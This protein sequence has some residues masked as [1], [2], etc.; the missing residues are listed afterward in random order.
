MSE[1]E[2]ASS[3]EENQ[4][5]WP[6]WL[7]RTVGALAAATALVGGV[8]GL[9]GSIGKLDDF[10]DVFCKIIPVC[11]K[12][13]WVAEAPARIARRIT[14]DEEFVFPALTR[15]PPL[16]PVKGSERYEDV[17]DDPKAVT[18]TCAGLGTKAWKLK[19]GEIILDSD[20]LITKGW[21]S[22]SWIGEPRGPDLARF[23]AEAKNKLGWT[24][25]FYAHNSC[26]TGQHCFIPPTDIIANAD[27]TTISAEDCGHMSVGEM[28][29]TEDRSQLSVWIRGTPRNPTVWTI[30]AKQSVYK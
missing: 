26:Q 13:Q 4:K 9:L 16:G 22:S 19:T 3:Q 2:V 12:P 1:T 8:G 23:D 5:S 24:P 29:Y 17:A 28:N 7:R 27:S 10:P 11:A 30:I 14:Q 25:G 6:R 20:P 15:T 21:F 18:A